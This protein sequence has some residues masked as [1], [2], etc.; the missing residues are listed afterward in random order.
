MGEKR[1]QEAVKQSTDADFS[2]AQAY[3]FFAGDLR[4]FLR[5][6]QKKQVPAKIRHD[7]LRY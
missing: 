6:P 3:G 2:V 5:S 7:Q 4:L 1:G